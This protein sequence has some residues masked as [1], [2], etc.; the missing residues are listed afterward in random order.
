MAIFHVGKYVVSNMR[1]ARCDVSYDAVFLSCA[2]VTD[3]SRTL[4][5]PTELHGLASKHLHHHSDVSHFDSNL[6]I[7]YSDSHCYCSFNV[8]SDICSF[9]ASIWR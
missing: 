2:V 8:G 5:S 3:V 4:Q 1:L 7:L 9:S 6:F